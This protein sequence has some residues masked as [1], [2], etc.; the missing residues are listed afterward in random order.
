MLSRN[1]REQI[2]DAAVTPVRDSLHALFF[3]LVL[4]AAAAALAVQGYYLSDAVKI[5]EKQNAW[6]R[7]EI[8]RA[9]RETA[10]LSNERLKDTIAAVLER[11]KIVETIESAFVPSAEAIAELSRL[12]RGVILTRI[13]IDGRR[14]IALGELDREATAASIPAALAQ[15]SFLID[16]RVTDV[17]RLEAAHGAAPSAGHSFR[18]EAGL[19]TLPNL[20]RAQRTQ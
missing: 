10:P 5:V 2:L 3:A 18:L 17:Q 12:P 1:A 6:I 14:L 13:E 9:E 7:D 11:K 19:P 8:H 20:R 16:A 15:S 4:V